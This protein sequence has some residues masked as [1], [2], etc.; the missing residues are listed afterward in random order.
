MTKKYKRPAQKKGHLQTHAEQSGAAVDVMEPRVDVEAVKKDTEATEQNQYSA[1]TQPKKNRCGAQ[2]KKLKRAKLEKARLEKARN[3][4][5]LLKLPREL[6]QNILLLTY[7]KEATRGLSTDMEE[8][9]QWHYFTPLTDQLRQFALSKARDDLNECNLIFQD[10]REKRPHTCQ[11]CF[12]AYIRLIGRDEK[13][14]ADWALVLKLIHPSLL[15]DAKF[16][17]GKLAMEFWKTL[18]MENI[19][20][21]DI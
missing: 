11:F 17:A 5:S 2:K 4:P 19:E 3:A 21:T 6:R 8:Y 9:C 12:H 1:P 18:R 20:M 7:N 14:L 16:A 15:D 10:A 13:K